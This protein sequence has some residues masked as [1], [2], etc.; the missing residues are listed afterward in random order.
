[1]IKDSSLLTKE[2]RDLLFKVRNL[3]E[4]IVETLDILEDKD[5]MDSIKEAEDDIRKG[6]I[7]NYKDYLVELKKSGNI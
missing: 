2:D 4:E 7:K 6:R 1:M 5:T 3:L